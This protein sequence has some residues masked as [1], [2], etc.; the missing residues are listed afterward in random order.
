MPA[1]ALIIQMMR[2]NLKQAV[3]FAMTM[4]CGTCVAPFV[5]HVHLCQIL[6]WAVAVPGSCPIF[7]SKC[8]SQSLDILKFEVATIPTH[9]PT[10]VHYFRGFFANKNNK[11]S[12]Y[13]PPIQSLTEQTRKQWVDQEHTAYIP[14]MVTSRRVH[15][16]FRTCTYFSKGN[17]CKWH[18][19]CLSSTQ[20]HIQ[21]YLCMSAFKASAV[22]GEPYIKSLSK[23]NESYETI[24]LGVQSNQI[25]NKLKSQNLLLSVKMSR[26]KDETL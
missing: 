15:N 8:W 23:R 26:V 20:W 2:W 1:N 17:Y 22:N 25:R 9:H 4:T 7:G 16:H 12:W 13:Q 14:M 19:S 3:P 21:L 11:M 10:V 6:S 18:I 5:G 24:K